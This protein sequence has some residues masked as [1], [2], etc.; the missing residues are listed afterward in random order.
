MGRAFL[1]PEAT[2]TRRISRAKQQ[3]KDSA[4]PFRM[5]AAQERAG[6]LA[7]VLH[8][9]YL[10]FSEGY[11]STSG[12]NLQRAELAAEAIPLPRTLPPLPPADPHVPPPLPLTL[13]TA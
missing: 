10:I 1:V 8:V 4:V 11:A 7:A 2:M 12:P 13:P 6:R 5:P 3:I 9:L